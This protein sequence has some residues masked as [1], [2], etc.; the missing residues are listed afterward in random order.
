VR[1]LET[2]A[3]D[4]LTKPFEIDELV[5][6]LGAV[7]RRTGPDERLRV[8]ALV[9]DRNAR[10]ADLDGAPLDLTA[11]EFDLLALLA[12]NAPNVVS[13]A[14]ILDRVW[15]EAADPHPNVVDV[16]IGYI[17][18]KLPSDGPPEIVTIRG[19]GF[20]LRG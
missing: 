5:A 17:R 4:Y 14:A 15:R 10:S 19:I 6:R 9:I 8:G 3:D 16:Y 11:R 18:R 20:S 2:G 13:R 1:N 12:A 7:M